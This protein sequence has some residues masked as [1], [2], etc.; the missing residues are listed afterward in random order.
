MYPKH[1]AY[2]YG[3]IASAPLLTKVKTEVSWNFMSQ[4]SN[5]TYVDMR[6]IGKTTKTRLHFS[7]H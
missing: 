7:M 6:I 4:E 2:C 1:E 5:V 3:A